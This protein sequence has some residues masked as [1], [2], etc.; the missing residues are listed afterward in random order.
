MPET[1]KKIVT[2]HDL[3]SIRY[4][5]LYNPLDAFIYSAKVKSACRHADKILATSIQTKNDV[6]DFL[7]IEPSKIEVVYQGCH[8][9]FKKN[10]S[11]SE[12]QNIKAKYDLPQEYILNVGTIEERKNVLLLIKAIALLPQDLRRCIVIV[13]ERLHTR[14]DFWKKHSDGE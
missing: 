12:I 14:P 9:T 10:F 1:V 13:G 4:P 7:K 11:P 2:V 6:V 8:P 5:K 3:I